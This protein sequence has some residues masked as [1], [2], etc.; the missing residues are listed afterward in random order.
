[1][2]TPIHEG[3]THTYHAASPPV[4]DALHGFSA[5]E[6][7]N[8]LVAIAVYEGSRRRKRP[9]GGVV[10]DLEDGLFLLDLTRVGGRHRLICWRYGRTVVIAA[11]VGRRRRI[12]QAEVRAGQATRSEWRRRSRS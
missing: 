8:L 7:T 2:D 4:G 10:Q 12:G 6:W 3:Q 9:P 1:M 5:D 11:V